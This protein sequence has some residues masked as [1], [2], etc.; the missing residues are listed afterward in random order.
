MVI[1]TH[2]FLRVSAEIG[3]PHIEVSLGIAH[4]GNEVVKSLL[5]CMICFM[6]PYVLEPEI[7]L[8]GGCE[9]VVGKLRHM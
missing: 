4:A 2:L 3:I 1:L 7:I 8:V 6:E 9:H 5:A